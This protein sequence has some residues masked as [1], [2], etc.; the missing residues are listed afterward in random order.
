MIRIIYTADSIASYIET[1]KSAI[2]YFRTDDYNC[3]E[4]ESEEQ[5]DA[6]VEAIES[7]PQNKAAM[8]A[9]LDKMGI[10]YLSGDTNSTLTAKIEAFIAESNYPPEW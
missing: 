8:Q 1:V 4:F 9:F 6:F 2:T 3:K 10:P 7:R 5:A